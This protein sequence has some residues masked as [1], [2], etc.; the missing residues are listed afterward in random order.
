MATVKSSSILPSRENIVEVEQ[1]PPEAPQCSTLPPPVLEVSLNASQRK[2]RPQ[3][4][5]SALLLLPNDV[6]LH[7]D[8]T[9]RRFRNQRWFL[10]QFR[11]N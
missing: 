5:L 10:N 9:R 8:Q 7:E 3:K 6:Y 11:E 2:G 4:S 1:P